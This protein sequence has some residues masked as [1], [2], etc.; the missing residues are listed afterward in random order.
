MS[1]KQVSAYAPAPPPAGEHSLNR[2][3]LPYHGSWVDLFRSELYMT[4][5]ETAFPCGRDVRF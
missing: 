5:R 1:I 4:D 3:I 2:S